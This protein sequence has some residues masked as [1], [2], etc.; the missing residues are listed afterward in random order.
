MEKNTEKEREL[1][2]QARFHIET[3]LAIQMKEMRAKNFLKT[4]KWLPK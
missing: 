4:R 3:G 2:M 1:E